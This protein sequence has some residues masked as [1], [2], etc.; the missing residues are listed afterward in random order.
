MQESNTSPESWD[1]GQMNDTPEERISVKEGEGGNRG[2][3]RDGIMSP[4]REPSDYF[5][6]SQVRLEVEQ[7]ELDADSDI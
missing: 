2:V 7:D 4:K 6:P 5:P 1:D 3:A